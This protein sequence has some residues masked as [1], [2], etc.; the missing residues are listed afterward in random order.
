MPK[1]IYS[2]EYKSGGTSQHGLD[3]ARVLT[4]AHV[5]LDSN[6]HHDVEK[7]GK[8][9]LELLANN[10]GIPIPEKR[11]AEFKKKWMEDILEWVN[12]KVN[13]LDHVNDIDV[14]ILKGLTNFFNRHDTTD[15]VHDQNKLNWLEEQRASWRGKQNV[16]IYIY[17]YFLFMFTH[18]SFLL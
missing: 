9:T 11:T 15:D 18:I 7:I 6:I 2:N 8:H 14:Q 4:E 17:I 13:I 10:C 16:Y 1:L 5:W 3:K 12:N